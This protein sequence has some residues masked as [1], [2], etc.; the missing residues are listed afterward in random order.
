[1]PGFYRL[2]GLGAQ[3]VKSVAVNAFGIG[4]NYVCAL[5]YPAHYFIYQVGI[6]LAAPH[7]KHGAVLTRPESATVESGD[8]APRLVGYVVG[9]LLPFRRQDKELYRLLVGIHY[10]VGQNE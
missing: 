9:N 5:I 10:V 1:M 8:T 2:S 7:Y 6:K 4:L 3:W